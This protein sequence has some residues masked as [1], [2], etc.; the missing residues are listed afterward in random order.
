MSSSA[1]GPIP[2]A[3][4]SPPLA[5]DTAATH[6]AEQLDRG[7]RQVRDAGVA[8]V[9]ISALL[10]GCM[11]IFA[12]LAY[13]QGVSA[14]TALT[15]RFVIAALVLGLFVLG[16]SRGSLQGSPRQLLGIAIFGILGYGSFSLLLFESLKR[17]S[18]TQT[19]LLFYTYPTLVVVMARVVYKEAITAA[20]L[21]AIALTIL[22]CALLSGAIPWRWRL[23]PELWLPIAASFVYAA[24]LVIGQRLLKIV[25]PRA[26]VFYVNTSLAV[27]LAVYAWLWP[28][29]VSVDM[30]AY[31][32]AA[33]AA[34]GVTSCVA[35]ILLF[36]GIA[37]IGAAKAALISTAEPLLSVLLAWAVLGEKL[38]I[39]EAVGGCL[40][41]ASIVLNQ[42]GG[43]HEQ[44]G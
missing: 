28:G 30:P 44:R 33:V 16:T 3:V 4:R 8:L 39:F 11:S 40:V 2:S 32:W 31:G 1:S 41:V 9:L 22:G 24:Y 17:T 21:A 6:R 35:P 12:K 38:S 23:G 20:R 18:A 19:A 13:A 37:R 34:I 42:K 43:A 36:S 29:V 14:A 27:V 15:F 10:F 26:L 25:D 5:G 7:T